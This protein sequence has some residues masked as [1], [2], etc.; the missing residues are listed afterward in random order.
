MMLRKLKAERVAAVGRDSGKG[1]CTV[2]IDRQAVA[3]IAPQYQAGSVKG[4][5]ERR[6][7]AKS[8]RA[9]RR[10]ERPHEWEQTGRMP[11]ERWPICYRQP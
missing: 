3:T 10:P 9:C 7:V 8:T 2:G 4:A 11:I 1:E 5:L 6:A